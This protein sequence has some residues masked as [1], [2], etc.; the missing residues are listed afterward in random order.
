MICSLCLEE[1]GSGD[2]FIIVDGRSRHDSCSKEF[3]E[4]VNEL[5][6]ISTETM[7]EVYL[8]SEEHDKG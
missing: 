5:E 7:P 3:E 1:I 4:M 2:H 6:K 8:D